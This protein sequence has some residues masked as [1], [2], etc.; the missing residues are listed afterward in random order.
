MEMILVYVYYWYILVYLNFIYLL[1]NFYS[2]FLN[3][4]VLV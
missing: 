2:Y 4:F 1:F 3:Q